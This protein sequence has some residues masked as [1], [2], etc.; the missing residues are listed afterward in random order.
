MKYFKILAYIFPCFIL[1]LSGCKKDEQ[2]Q[3]YGTATMLLNGRNW[4]PLVGGMTLDKKWP[5]SLYSIKFFYTYNASYNL[6]IGLVCVPKRTGTFQIYKEYIA[7]GSDTNL[8]LNSFLYTVET[9]TANLLWWDLYEPDSA[10]NK[11]II[12]SFNKATN[13]FSGSFQC[14]YLAQHPDLVSDPPETIRIKNAVFS[15]RI[16]E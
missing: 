1:C 11:L 10:T 5:D 14:T 8:L 16:L 7:T 13:S 6:Y 15:G 9:G 12:T 4:S 2:V 3:Q